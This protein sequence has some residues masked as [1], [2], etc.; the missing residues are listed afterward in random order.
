MIVHNMNF[1]TAVDFVKSLPPKPALPNDIRLEF[2]K[3]YKQATLGDINCKRPLF[4][5]VEGLKWDAWNSIKGMPQET[6][7]IKYVDLLTNYTAKLNK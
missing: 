5:L 6:A 2:Y 4:N 1:E 7:K 3:F